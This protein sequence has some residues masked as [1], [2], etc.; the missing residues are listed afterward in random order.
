VDIRLELASSSGFRDG[1]RHLRV[2]EKAADMMT[3]K[4]TRGAEEEEDT[5]GRGRVS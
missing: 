3:S 1:M 5:S 4:D 2:E